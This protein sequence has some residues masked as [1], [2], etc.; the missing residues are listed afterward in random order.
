ML[1]CA[2]ALSLVLASCSE[3]LDEGQDYADW[4]ARNEAYFHEQMLTARAAVQQAKQRYGQQW[5]QHCPWRLLRTYT[6]AP[7][8]PATEQDS[9]CAEVIET[10]TGATPIYT[11]SVS[12]Q[13]RGC[14]IPHRT[15]QMDYTHELRVFDYTG[16]SPA[17]DD[18]FRSA[19]SK[20]AQMSVGLN[21]VA[22]TT[23]S[24]SYRSNIDGFTTAL[25][26]M[27]EGDLWRVYVPAN[28]A[29]KGNASG[30]IIQPWSTLIF[31][32]RLVKVN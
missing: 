21:A 5:Q 28:L 4:Q 13:Y 15:T 29:Y 6:L 7:D 24:V 31:E 30:N 25:L 10:G 12:L 26:H 3:N 16:F 9:L 17:F 32:L 2:A 14:L 18:V 11:D 1:L 8:A 20:P 19:Y 27:R 22:S 23:G